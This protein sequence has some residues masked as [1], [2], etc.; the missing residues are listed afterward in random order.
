MKNW[1]LIT[2][3]QAAWAPLLVFSFYVIAAEGFHL[4]LEFPNM[5]IPTHFAGGVAM[6]YFYLT[7]IRHSQRMIGVIPYIIHPIL[8]TSLTAFTAVVWELLE[9]FSDML[10]ATQ[11]NLG[12]NDTLSDL[13]CGMIGALVVAL[14]AYFYHSKNASGTTE[15]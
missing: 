13:L 2:F 11:L 1:I 8:A 4:Y 3:R 7:A 10:F 5:D 9:K 14:V 6:T 12:A 15:Q